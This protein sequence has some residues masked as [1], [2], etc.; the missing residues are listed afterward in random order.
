[1]P[2]GA[3]KPLIV[4]YCNPNCA[5]LTLKA[6][7]QLKIGCDHKEHANHVETLA[8]ETLASLLEDLT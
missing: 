5:S 2:D 7:A 6:G 3:P 8:T 1:L 4:C